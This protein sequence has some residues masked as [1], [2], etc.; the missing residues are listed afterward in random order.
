MTPIIPLQSLTIAMLPSSFATFLVRSEGNEVRTVEGMASFI[1]QSVE[2][3]DSP[4]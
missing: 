1:S 2:D 3:Q 4:Y